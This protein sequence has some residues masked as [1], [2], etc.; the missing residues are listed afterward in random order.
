L[1]ETPDEIAEILREAR[2]VAVGGHT[3]EALR[4]RRAGIRVVEERCAVVTHRARF[5]DEG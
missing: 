3:E 1:S 2:T 5:Q 4:L